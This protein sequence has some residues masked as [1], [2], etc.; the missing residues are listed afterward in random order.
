[1]AI[2]HLVQ[3]AICVFGCAFQEFSLFRHGTL[4]SVPLSPSCIQKSS[5]LLI[6]FL[7]GA[8]LDLFSVIYLP[9]L[10]Y[11]VLSTTHLVFFTI[12]YAYHQGAALT[13][14]EN[15]GIFSILFASLTISALGGTQTDFS[16]I[17]ADSFFL[18]FAIISIFFSF[19]LRKLSFYGE[20]VLVDT[21]IPGQ[22]SIMALGTIK[23][24]VFVLQGEVGQ[25]FAIHFIYPCVL[26]IW[27]LGGLSSS[28]LRIFQKKHDLIAVYGGYLIWSLLWALPI[29]LGFINYSVDYEKINLA[30]SIFSVVLALS[31]VLILTY[32]RVELLKS[33]NDYKTTLHPPRPSRLDAAPLPS[34]PNSLELNIEDE[35]LMDAELID[36]DLLIK[37]IRNL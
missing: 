10:T 32:Q 37:T 4:Y 24:C 23:M 28:F 6:N 22:L 19:S 34:E 27:V 17:P 15:I 12:Y 3:C 9:L 13:K 25:D 29:S 5:F 30:F 1:M 7:V 11:V 14:S 36:E 2:R 33:Q 18:I 31:G 35:N 20:K 21:L 8:S 26:F 16:P